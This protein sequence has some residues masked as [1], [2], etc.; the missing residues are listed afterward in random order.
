MDGHVW[1][2]ADMNS[3]EVVGTIDALWRFP[4]KSMQGERLDEAIVG[5]AGIIGDRAYAVVDVSHGQ[6]GERQTP[7]VVARAAFMSGHVYRAAA[8][9]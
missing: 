3:S 9:G 5:E 4:V 2:Q 1:R 8:L 7:E 6:S